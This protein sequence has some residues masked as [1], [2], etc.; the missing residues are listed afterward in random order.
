M[1]AEKNKSEGVELVEKI[2]FLIHILKV[3]NPKIIYN[4]KKERINK[5]LETTILK[6]LTNQRLYTQIYII[7][8]V[9]SCGRYTVVYTVEII[10][11]YSCLYN[12]NNLFFFLSETKKIILIKE[13]IKERKKRQKKEKKTKGRMRGL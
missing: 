13:Q 5:E 4:S 7:V 3:Y 8:V 6:I 11:I 1:K 12:C 10:F 2:V 9:Y